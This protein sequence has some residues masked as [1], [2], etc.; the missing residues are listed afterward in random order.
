MRKR[1][2]N[3][4]TVV[5]LF[6]ITWVLSKVSKILVRFCV[7]L[8]VWV[9]E[10]LAVLSWSLPISLAPSTSTSG[11]SDGT[12]LSNDFWVVEVLVEELV[13]DVLAVVEVVVLS[14]NN[15]LN[16]PPVVFGIWNVWTHFPAS[17]MIEPL[18]HL[19]GFTPAAFAILRLRLLR[20]TTIHFEPLGQS[21][22][23]WHLM[24][25]SS[26]FPVGNAFTQSVFVSK[27]WAD[28]IAATTTAK[29]KPTKSNAI[30]LLKI[31]VDA[32]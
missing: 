14:S 6:L 1:A 24:Q 7:V 10:V 26:D 16:V 11:L 21:A 23:D 28:A 2:R 4:T 18:L 32:F 12:M 9:V 3:I 27:G 22:K 19:T 29:D 31:F 20:S 5:S 13:V 30:I 8:K 15:F 25:S 17:S